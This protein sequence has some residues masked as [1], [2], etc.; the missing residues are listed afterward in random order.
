MLSRNVILSDYESYH[1]FQKVLE[2][3]GVFK[4]LRDAGIKEGDV[5]RM[6]DIEFEYTE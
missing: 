2:E 3:R 4:A 6:K 1:Y 5:V